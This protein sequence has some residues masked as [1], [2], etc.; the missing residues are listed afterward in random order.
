MSPFGWWQRVERAARP[1]WA[2]KDR[3]VCLYVDT[4]SRPPVVHLNPAAVVAVDEGGIEILCND[5][6][7]Y[8]GVDARMFGTRNGDGSRF[9]IDLNEAVCEAVSHREI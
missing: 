7:M 8:I 1:D 9:D 2:G 5:G 6:Y 3:N 4:V